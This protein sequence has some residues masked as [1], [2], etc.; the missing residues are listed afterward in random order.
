MLGVLEDGGEC[1]VSV[2][3]CVEVLLMSVDHS[4][5][6]V[7]ALLCVSLVSSCL[8]FVVVV[9][10]C[11]QLQGIGAQPLPQPPPRTP[12]TPP[13]APPLTQP[14]QPPQPIPIAP[15]SLPFDI[16]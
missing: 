12:Q 9:D 2:G 13:Q 10:C 7:A 16:R 4:L 14:E 5:L 11:T 6:R 1:F 15:R 8:L 3:A